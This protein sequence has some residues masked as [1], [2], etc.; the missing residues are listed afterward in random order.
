[1]LALTLLE[2]CPINQ[3]L[4]SVGVPAVNMLYQGKHLQTVVKECS[5]F[6]GSITGQALLFDWAFLAVCSL[7]YIFNPSSSQASLNPLPVIRLSFLSV[8]NPFLFLPHP[9]LSCSSLP[10]GRMTATPRSPRCSGR[11]TVFVTLC[12]PICLRSLTW[13]HLVSTSSRCLAWPLLHLLPPPLVGEVVVVHVLTTCGFL[14]PPATCVMLCFRG[15]AR[16]RDLNEPYHFPTG[17][18]GKLQIGKC[19]NIIGTNIL[20]L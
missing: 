18:R 8:V 1:M 16:T 4:L 20:W 19:A 7:L 3:A 13:C 14:Y 2:K 17:C 5:L 10:P 9:P 11:G 15:V 12:F 6:S